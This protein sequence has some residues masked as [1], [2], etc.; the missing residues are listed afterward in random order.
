MAIRF[1]ER[2]LGRVWIHPDSV[3]FKAG[4]Y[5]SCMCVRVWGAREG[6]G[7]RGGGGGGT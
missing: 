2:G 6:G 3:C 1:F 7:A 4:S 5:P